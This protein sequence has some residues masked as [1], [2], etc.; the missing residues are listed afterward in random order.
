MKKSHISLLITT[1]LLGG[2]GQEVVQVDITTSMFPH[3]DLV[4]EVS[5]GSD[6]T[7]SLIV[8][9]GVEVHSYRPTPKQ[10]VAINQSQVFF[11]SSDTIETWVSNLTVDTVK[12]INVHEALFADDEDEHL[13]ADDE[14]HH[15]GVH[16]WTNPE[17]F[18]LEMDLV[19]N[20]LSL[21]QPDN[22]ELFTANANAYE[23]LIIR[24]S[25]QFRTDISGLTNPTVFFVGHNTMEDFGE[26]FNLDIVPL[27]EDIKP[28]A[29]VTPAQLSALVD[30]IVSSNASHIFTE[31]LAST[32]FAD[33]VRNELK[34]KHGRDIEI[35]ELHGYH[36]VTETDYRN[37]V[38]YLDL[39]ERN[40]TH[41]K[42]ALL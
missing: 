39:L 1:L 4:R 36:N 5:E 22:A 31:E 40:F 32:R 2:C 26:Y 9:P 28:D 12:I 16:Y 21:I 25:N 8:P 15:H 10:T 27:V 6:L 29:D 19:V 7:Y 20:E 30:A 33:T 37:E 42:A 24:A 18:V 11:Y 3:Y 14:E 35:Q 34:T 38:T 41:L 23:D 17:N 13:H